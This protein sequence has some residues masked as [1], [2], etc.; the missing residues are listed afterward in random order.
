ME[1]GVPSKGWL[2]GSQAP[3]GLAVAVLML[4]GAT[5]GHG[6]DDG[7]V[8]VT[9]QVAVIGTE[10]RVSLGGREI[11]GAALV[12]MVIS[13]RDPAGA[14]M[15]IRIDSVQVDPADPESETILYGLSVRNPDGGW[16]NLCA[17]G[18]DGIALGFPIG[19]SHGSE[20]KALAGEFALTCTGGAVGKCVR[21]GYKPWKAGPDGNSLA[22]LHAAC[23]RMIMADYCGD[24]VSR[25][26]DGTLVD[27]YDPLGIQVSGGSPTLSFEAGWD[28]AGAVCVHHPRVPG[29]ASLDALAKACPRRLAGHVGEMC[30]DD[31]ARARGAL[32]L[33]RSAP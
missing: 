29:L 14:E 12:G 32:V 11:S 21:L 18:P 25:T 33:N 9:A 17:P 7:N 27:V 23:V 4:S 31:E 24:G 2:R 19:P 28:P 8:H 5:A 22:P 1:A 6:G 30:T 16:R 15:G 10:L 20:G 26:L 3:V 13:L